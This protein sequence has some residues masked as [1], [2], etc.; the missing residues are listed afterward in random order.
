MNPCCA[1]MALALDGAFNPTDAPDTGDAV[2]EN[3]L[4]YARTT[5]TELRLERAARDGLGRDYMTT[6]IHF[7]PW[8][9]AK[10]HLPLKSQ[11]FE[12]R[13]WTGGCDGRG[14]SHLT[15]SKPFVKGSVVLRFEGAN[16]CL[17]MWENPEDRAISVCDNAQFPRG[18]VVSYIVEGQK[19]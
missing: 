19:S 1:K 9:G 14:L 10:M 11:P 5:Y 6:L 15:L 3:T 13:L 12:E 7:C 4:I 16:L 17:P 18:Y 2:F 8:C